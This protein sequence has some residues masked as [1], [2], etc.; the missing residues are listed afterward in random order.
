[1]N[2]SMHGIFG[3]LSAM[4]LAES[5]NAQRYAYFAEVA[6]IEGHPDIAALLGELAQSLSCA[7]HGHFDFLQ[8][9]A[10]PATNQ[11]IGETSLNLASAITSGL[12]EA[13]DRYPALAGAAHADGLAD[14]ASWLETMSALKKAHVAKLDAALSK[15]N[16]RENGRPASVD[17]QSATWSINVDPYLEDADD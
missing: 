7:A 11:P 10:D 2:D 12:S 13:N 6:Q 9:I 1:M 15:L 16:A 17:R 8:Q 14:T 5:A 3:E 4:F